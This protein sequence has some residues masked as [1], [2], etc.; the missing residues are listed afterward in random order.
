MLYNVF[1]N[2]ISPAINV[3]NIIDSYSEE[4]CTALCLLAAAAAAVDGRSF[5]IANGTHF[6][7]SAAAAT[8]FTEQYF[9]FA[10]RSENVK[11]VQLALPSKCGR[12]YTLQRRW[13]LHLLYFIMSSI[14]IWENRASINK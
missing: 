8:H 3:N 11:L 2:L 12:E 4:R 7:F 13:Q 1:S 14:Y 5:R 6:L 10:A 9:N